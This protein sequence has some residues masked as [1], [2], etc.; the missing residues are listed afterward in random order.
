MKCPKCDH[1]SDDKVLVRCSNC[2]ETFERGVIEELAHL[3]YL[4]NWVEKHREEIGEAAL[5][6]IMGRTGSR[7][8]ELLSQINPPPKEEIP[9]PP[10]TPVAVPAPIPEPPPELV[11]APAP[12]VAPKVERT[13]APVI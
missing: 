12:V 2:G 11:P 7:V 8:D 9:A 6:F 1:V 10:P 13:P 3:N 4:Q 5:D